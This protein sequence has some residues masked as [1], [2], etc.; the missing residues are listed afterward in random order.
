M[1]LSSKNVYFSRQEHE[2]DKKSR[3][4]RGRAMMRKRV[5]QGK[6]NVMKHNNSKIRVRGRVR[7]TKRRKRTIRKERLWW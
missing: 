4:C 1:F 2:R 6:I 7:R 3:G 5:R